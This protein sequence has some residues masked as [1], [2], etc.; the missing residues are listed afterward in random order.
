MKVVHC[1]TGLTADGA[2][3]MLLRL[4]T[5]LQKKGFQNYVVSLER[6][7]PFAEMFEAQGIEVFSLGS[8]GGGSWIRCLHSL[9]TVLSSLK[10]S[11]IQG[12]MYHANLALSLV[13]S[14]DPG[15]KRPLWNIRRGVD[16]L[17]E[18]KLLT[19]LVVRA[20][21]L[22]S[23]RTAHIIY[24]T[25]ESRRQH[26]RIGFSHE[27]GVVIGNG[28]DA[29]RFRPRAELGGMLRMKLSLRPDTIIIGNV[30]R[31]DLAK[32]KY[33]LLDAVARLHQRVPNIHLVLVGRG[34]T[35]ENLALRTRIQ[36]LGL[37]SV[38]TLYG[39]VSSLEDLYPAFDILCSS[40]VNEGFPNVIAEAMLSGVACVVTDVGNSRA[41][42]EGIGVVVPPRC[43]R[44]LADGLFDMCVRAGEA[45]ADAGR[46]GRERIARLYSLESVAERYA[47][48]YSAVGLQEWRTRSFAQK[49]AIS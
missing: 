1:I 15:I 32:G 10:P 11:V 28:F 3:R 45:R 35:P 41:L 42:V 7:E 19:R 37:T 39:E 49:A 8:E 36:E 14:V 16:D 31:Y 22:L 29:Q 46:Q 13:S 43:A 48:L 24:C 20:N 4:S 12:W 2:Q 9:R 25:D 26:E 38:V 21:A 27:R 44:S 33:Y 34:M 6:R 23:S 47:Q 30:G 18:R 5:E 40:S 17:A